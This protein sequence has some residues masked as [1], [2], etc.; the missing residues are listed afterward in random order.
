M[1]DLISKKDVLAIIDATLSINGDRQY[2]VES[3]KHKIDQFPTYSIPFD[4]AADYEEIAK[5]LQTNDMNV[6]Y[7][8]MIK[9]Y[10]QQGRLTLNNYLMSGQIYKAVSEYVNESYFTVK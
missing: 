1:V 5:R 9:V 8:E 7:V 3:L 10:I 6:I 4:I 2:E